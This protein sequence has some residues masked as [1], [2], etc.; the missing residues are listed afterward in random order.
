MANIDRTFKQNEKHEMTLRSVSQPEGG[1][2]QYGNTESYHVAREQSFDMLNPELTAVDHFMGGLAS[3]VMLAIQHYDQKHGRLI[4]EMEGKF[5]F[6]LAHPMTYLDV[7][8]YEGQCHI[9]AWSLHLY[10]VS[11]EEEEDVVASVKAGLEKSILYQT[12]KATL[13][14]AL[15]VKIIL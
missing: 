14:L 15:H 4:E 10:I 1:V 5:S 7:I 8:G 3:S 6:T 2:E 12:V 13:P 9:S 11:Y